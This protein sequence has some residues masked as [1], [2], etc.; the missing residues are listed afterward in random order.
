VEA[1]GRT[2]LFMIDLNQ[3][4]RIFHK[5]NEI[6]QKLMELAYYVYGGARKFMSYEL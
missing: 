5:G 1:K 2:N 4:K 3:N 6:V